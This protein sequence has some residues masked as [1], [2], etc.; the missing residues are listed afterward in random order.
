[1]ISLG[2]AWG[3]TEAIGW[4]RERFFWIYLIESLPALVVPMLFPDLFGLAIGMMV[5]FVFVL[6]GPGIMVGLIAGKKQIMGK[7]ASNVPWTIMYWISL[8]V[9]VASGLIA[10]A[11]VFS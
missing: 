4:G 7:L 11:A 1:V 6:L 8:A 5:L 2:S 9:V 3:V 10:L